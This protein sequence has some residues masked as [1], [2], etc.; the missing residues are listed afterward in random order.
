MSPS[1]V[2]AGRG[3]RVT[4]SRYEVYGPRFRK[5]RAWSISGLGCFGIKVVDFKFKALIQAFITE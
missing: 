3:Q 2:L 1:F 5:V 4:V